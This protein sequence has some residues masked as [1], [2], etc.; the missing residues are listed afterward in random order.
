MVATICMDTRQAS[1][2]H[3]TVKSTLPYIKGGVTLTV[4]NPSTGMKTCLIQIH[5]LM[6]HCLVCLIKS[7]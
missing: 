3:S 2:N 4:C 5:I 7:K 6:F 1:Q